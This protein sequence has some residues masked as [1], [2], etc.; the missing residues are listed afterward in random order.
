MTLANIIV[1]TA[2]IT[3]ERTT[4]ISKWKLPVAEDLPMSN[5]LLV[6]LPPIH[7]ISDGAVYPSFDLSK[8]LVSFAIFTG[9]Q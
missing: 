5:A 4:P 9:R 6:P 1:P 3:V 8:T 7:V 2:I